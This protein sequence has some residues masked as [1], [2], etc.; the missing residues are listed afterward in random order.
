MGRRRRKKHSKD[1]LNLEK[2]RQRNN[3]INSWKDKHDTNVYDDQDI[4]GVANEYYSDLFKA[5]P[6]S[7]SVFLKKLF[8]S[9]YTYEH[10]L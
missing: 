9:V 7:N 10:T 6:V 2:E 1:F 3:C 8:F 5:K 4:L